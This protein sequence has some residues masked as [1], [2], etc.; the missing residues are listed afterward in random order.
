MSDLVRVTPH[1]AGAF[2]QVTFG[3]S[4]GNILDLATVNALSRAFIDARTEGDLKAICLEG[5]GPDFSFGA[6]IQEHLPD[7]AAEMIG[8]MRQ[9][10]LD[11]LESHVMVLAA[12]RG[13]CL[14]GGLE[15]ASV[16]HRVFAS[17]DATFGQPEIAIGVFAPF[18]SVLLPE[19]IARAHAED[20][21]LT[22]RTIDSSEA[23][24][25]GVVDELTSGDPGTA[26]LEW[27]RRHL[28]P[29]S[30]SSLRFAA[31]ALRAGFTARVR[32]DLP[33]VEVLYL[34]ELMGTTDA[35]EG[36]DAFLSKR[37]PTWKNR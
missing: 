18:A 14:G 26:A 24:T 10:L 5:A 23:R 12:V 1:D 3:A 21:C 34:K 11:L 2:W 7:R 33:A 32:E 15:V 9:L 13:R 8:G 20:L 22:G 4:K 6:S 16:C 17:Q 27:A 25:M 31:R 28:G 29:H 19:R 36:L 37:R 35:R 30:A